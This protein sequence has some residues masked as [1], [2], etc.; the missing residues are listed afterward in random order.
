[1]MNE[2]DTEHSVASS[3][4]FSTLAFALARHT[5]FC[6]FSSLMTRESTITRATTNV[7][8]SLSSMEDSTSPYFLHNSDHPGIV[9]IS[10]HLIGANYNTW[11]R[12]MV[13]TLTAKNKIN[14]IDGSIPCP[15]YDDLLFG[16][17]IR[18]NSMVI[19]WILNSVHKDIVDSLLYFDTAVGIWNDLRDRFCQSNGLRIFQIKKHL[20]AL[21]QGS[22]DVIT[23]YTRLKILWD[24]LKGFQPLPECACGTMKTWMEFQQQEYVMQFLM[25]LNE[26]FVQT[27]S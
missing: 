10:H 5:L 12:A 26:S 21:N 7:P 15:E 17:W 6:L 9:L 13:L 11:S 20:I 25:G 3:L 16:T 23:Y 4:P 18:Y 14:F 27:R 2:N 19:S 22:L 8:N 1:M 24:G